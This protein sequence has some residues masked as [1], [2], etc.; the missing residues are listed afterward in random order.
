MGR[1]ARR[2][3]LEGYLEGVR[4]R[5]D[6]LDPSDALKAR[7]RPRWTGA[8]E[9][10]QRGALD[11][12][13]SGLLGI[14]AELDRA[15]DETEVV[16][17]PR[18]LVAYTPIGGREAPPGPEEE[19]LA[20]R[21]RLLVRLAAVRASHGRDVSEAQALLAAAHRAYERGDRAAARAEADRA[22]ALLERE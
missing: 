10:W 20:N 1:A 12:A 9:A 14:D 21:L 19:P 6:A 22:H 8:R 7:L 16:E 15:R 13:E 3:E 17:R 4:I 5:I 18:G 2:E 11:E